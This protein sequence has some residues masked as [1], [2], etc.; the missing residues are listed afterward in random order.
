MEFLECGRTSDYNQIGTRVFG[1]THAQSSQ[2]PWM[3][4]LRFFDNINSTRYGLCG[5][6]LID[7]KHVMTAAHCV[8][9]VSK[10]VRNI[11][12]IEVYLG[13]KDLKKLNKPYRVS[14]VF[15]PHDYDQDSLYNDIA[16]LRLQKTVVQSPKVKPICLPKSDIL[17]HDL[18]TVIG[19][20]RLGPDKKPAKSLMQVNVEYID[21]KC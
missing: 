8:H 10:N 13:L 2:F 3:A 15:Y 16:I 5:G 9:D 19:Y 12:A 21:S 20:G 7:E 1:G 14:Q 17:P 11:K 6:Y 18:M 4:H